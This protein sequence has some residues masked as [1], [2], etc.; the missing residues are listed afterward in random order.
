VR[1]EREHDVEEWLRGRKGW[2]GVRIAPVKVENWAWIGFNVSVLA[3]VTIGEGAIVGAC[4]I[5]TKDVPAWT[6]AAGNPARLIRE[7][8][9]NERA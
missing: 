4:S 8:T 6:V 2:K 1:R 5:V 3:G 7:Q 9:A